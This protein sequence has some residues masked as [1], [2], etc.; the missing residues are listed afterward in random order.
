MNFEE[1]HTHHILE[2]RS[3]VMAGKLLVSIRWWR[4]CLFTK[5]IRLAPS[6]RV[7]WQLILNEVVSMETTRD[8]QGL[9][10]EFVTLDQLWDSDSHLYDVVLC[11]A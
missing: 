4:S 2:T 11:S 3:P 7:W 6:C 10:L 1:E 8:D 5:R 9:A